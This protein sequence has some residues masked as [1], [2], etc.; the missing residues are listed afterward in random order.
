MNDYRLRL[1]YSGSTGNAAL[2]EAE[3][4]AI[5]IDAGKSART[6]CAALTEAGCPPE[7]LSAVFLT[8]EHSDHTAALAVFLKRH[9][10]PVHITEPSAAAL[11]ACRGSACVAPHLVVHPPLFSV[12]VGP[13]CVSSFE[14]PHDSRYSVGYRVRVCREGRVHEIGY[15][16]DIGHVTD[17]VLTGFCGCEAA[18]VECNHDETMLMTGPYPEELKRRIASARGH[19][20]NA[21]CAALAQKLVA[22]G[23]KRLL[24][25]H[26]SETNN[27]PE[28]ALAAVT[29]A[30]CGTGVTVRAAAPDHVTEL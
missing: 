21:D 17:S 18:V 25:A 2:L 19:L 27:T 16:T 9:P 6:L 29:A 5:L 4:T 13:F 1:L 12:Q 24:L 28:L 26:L 7:K 23:A 20:S 30:L 8:H 10:V 3:D 15:A 22:A 14:T 11:L